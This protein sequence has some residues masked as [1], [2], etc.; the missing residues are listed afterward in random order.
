MF[1]TRKIVAAPKNGEDKEYVRYTA[2][3]LGN[4]TCGG[5]SGMSSHSTRDGGEVAETSGRYYSSAWTD[6]IEVMQAASV[7]PFYHCGPQCIDE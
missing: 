3:C 5:G 4:G 1:K 2:H 7:G 6:E